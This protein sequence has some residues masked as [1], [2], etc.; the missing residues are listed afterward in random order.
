M[1]HTKGQIS[2]SALGD[3]H[4]SL[5]RDGRGMSRETARDV[6]AERWTGD[7]PKLTL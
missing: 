7:A 2:P 4:K 6:L 1:S 5:K 3:E